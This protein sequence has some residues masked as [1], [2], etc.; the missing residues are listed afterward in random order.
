MYILIPYP[1]LHY[2]HSPSQRITQFLSGMGRWLVFLCRYYC[3]MQYLIAYYFINIHHA[4]QATSESL[5]PSP[6][7]SCSFISLLIL[8]DSGCSRLSLLKKCTPV[9]PTAFGSVCPYSAL[10][11]FVFPSL[12]PPFHRCRV[13]DFSND[14]ASGSSRG[15]HGGL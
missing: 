11:P 15:I 6:L 12:G 5:E 8:L 1:M 9:N 2:T 14:T 3:I 13:A 7:F 4:D 10:M